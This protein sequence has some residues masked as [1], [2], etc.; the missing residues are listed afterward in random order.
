MHVPFSAR[1]L[2]LALASSPLPLLAQSV[3]LQV[4]GGRSYMDGHGTP[5]L[6][7]EAV[8]DDHAIGDS[9]WSLAPDVSL[10]WID[11]RDIARFRDNRYPT[12]EQA[13]LLAAGARLQYR[14]ADGAPGHWFASFQPAFNTARTQALSSPYEFVTTLGWQ[15]HRFSFQIRHVSNARLHQPNRGETMA[16][17]GIGF[18]L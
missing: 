17:V 16:L 10:G 3:H 11:G 6:F 5:A 9:R 18:D 8:F 4:Q 1:L 12:R 15:G 13:W 14:T 7:V 2:L